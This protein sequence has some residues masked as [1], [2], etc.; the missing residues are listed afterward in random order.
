[1][2]G[3]VKDEWW[4]YY[5]MRFI[6]ADAGNGADNLTAAPASSVYPRGCGERPEVATQAGLRSGLSPRMRGTGLM[7]PVDPEEPR[8]I[9]ADAGNGQDL[10]D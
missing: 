7:S 8:F 5:D 6:P 3:T 4:Q 1:M 10:G 9:P 2:R